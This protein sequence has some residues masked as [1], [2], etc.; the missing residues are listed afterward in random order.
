MQNLKIQQ[1]PILEKSYTRADWQGGYQSLKEEFD[2]WIDDVEGEIPLELQGTLFRNG[3]GLFDVNGQRLHHPFDGDGM[4]SRVTFANGRAHFRNRFI[5]TEGYVAEQQAGKIL[6]RGVFG[7]QK[8]GGWLANIFDFKLK[9]IANTNVIY[10]GGQLLALWE[11]AEPHILDPHTLE[12]LG[13][14]YFNGVLSTGE[15]FSAH[16]RF[17]PSCEQDGGEPCL[18]NFSIKPGLSTTITIFEVNLAGQIVRK[19]AHSVPGFCFIHD[20]VITPQ[21]CIFFQNPVKFNPIPFVLGIRSAGECI[22]FQPHQPTRIIVI[23]RFPQTKEAKVK[24]LETQSGF[25]F[26]HINAFEVGNEIFIDSISYESLP[27]VEPE[28]DF[29]QVNFDAVS[30]GQ[31]WRFYLN[32]DD[33]TVQSK[34]IE[35]RCCEFPTLNPANVGRNYQYLYIG[36]AHAETGNAPLQALLKIDLESGKRQLWSAAPR[37]FMGEPIFVPRPGSKK[38]DDGW[39]LALVYDAATHR[40]DV[41]ILDASD[42]SKGAIARLHLKHHIPYGLHGSFTSEV[43][44]TT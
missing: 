20:F 8:P 23:P 34:L 22:D 39:V 14:E 32:L 4:I 40:S 6:Y 7:T 42:F 43:F 41:V 12:T 29:R 31:L 1:N 30:P 24:I 15:A 11:A 2:Y 28:S 27:E 16:P 18:V 3:P 13:R 17:D 5:R 38:E 19:H 26:H 37:G 10:W 44:V 9:N 36:A 21:Y 35:S 33:E 25:I